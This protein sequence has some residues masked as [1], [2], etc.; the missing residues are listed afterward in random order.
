MAD[1]IRPEDEGFVLYEQTPRRRTY[2]RRWR[3]GD[4]E[5][6]AEATKVRN[7]PCGPPVAT[8]L[9]IMKITRSYPTTSRH[10][11]CPL[12]LPWSPGTVSMGL[13]ARRAAAERVI[14]VHT[15][16]F[17]QFRREEMDSRV[18]SL[19]RQVLAELDKVLGEDGG[20]DV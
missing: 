4:L 11:S 7:T 15:D 2:V 6:C 8:V 19:T 9:T 5:A 16:L 13:R 18:A 20:A 12:H 14:A 3:E 17:E 10:A 1:R